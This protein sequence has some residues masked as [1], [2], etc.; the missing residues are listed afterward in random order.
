MV[1]SG[2]AGVRPGT[3]SVETAGQP[4]E[5]RVRQGP[6][7]EQ[8]PGRACHLTI[9]RTRRWNGPRPAPGNTGRDWGEA[10]KGWRRRAGSVSDRRLLT[11]VAD[12][13]GSSVAPPL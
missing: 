3:P 9:L 11:P 1:R 10:A 2:I 5:M 7:A 6:A 13:P 4:E 12:A 8:A